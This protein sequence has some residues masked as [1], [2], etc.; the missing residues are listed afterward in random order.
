M[1]RWQ[2]L[3]KKLAAAR[4]QTKDRNVQ[5]R[6]PERRSKTPSNAAEKHPERRS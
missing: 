5:P 6:P 1:N 2:E 3:S 4:P